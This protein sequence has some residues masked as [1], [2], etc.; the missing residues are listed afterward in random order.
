MQR[1]ERQEFVDIKAAG[2]SKVFANMEFIRCHFW[3][4]GIFPAED[5]ADRS[6]ARDLR[7][8]NCEETACMINGAIV[9]ETLVDGLRSADMF[10]TFGTVFKHVTLRGKIGSVMFSPLISPSRNDSQREAAYLEANARYYSR[11]DW[12]L[13]ISEGEFIECDLRG[14][15]GRLIRRDSKT[16]ALVT[17]EKAAEGAWRQLDLSRTW[18]DVSLQFLVEDGCSDTVLVAP[19]RHRK[20]RDLLDGIK[21]LRDI[22]VAEPD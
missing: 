14:I 8:I 19:K 1:F 4:C 16:Q 13:D 20:F 9:E 11:V 7:F 2:T 17:R 5:P 6:T 22:G 10:Q 21:M 18:W 12:A 15:P 3:A